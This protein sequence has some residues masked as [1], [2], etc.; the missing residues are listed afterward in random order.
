MVSNWFFGRR[1]EYFGASLASCSSPL[2]SYG[3]GELGS[4]DP[5]MP[6]PSQIKG[7]TMREII[8]TATSLLG[9]GAF[10]ILGCVCFWPN[11]DSFIEGPLYLLDR[12]DEW[13]QHL[14]AWIGI[15][16]VASVP[17]LAIAPVLREETM[18]K[19]ISVLLLGL[20][21]ALIMGV[22]YIV[23]AALDDE[24]NAIVPQVT[25][26]PLHDLDGDGLVGNEDNCESDP[27]PDQKD[28]DY[29]GLGDAC[30]PDPEDSD[31]D[32]DTVIDGADNC[33]SESNPDQMDEDEDGIGDKCEELIN[34]AGGPLSKRLGAFLL[35]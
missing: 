18:R 26:V 7:G 16:F 12:P 31:T 22:A 20:L 3:A 1:S 15:F 9:A 17:I 27:N 14:V 30:D 21:I 34:P 33:P 13:N 2:L 35:F 10:L 19:V 23:P 5:N 29:D 6:Q 25:V 28:T 8:T 11:C 24:S 4:D 32:D